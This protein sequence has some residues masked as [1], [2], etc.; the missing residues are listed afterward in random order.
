EPIF[1]ECEH[2]GRQAIALLQAAGDDADHPRVPPLA[3]HEDQTFWRGPRLHLLDRLLEH[4]SLGCPSL[5]VPGFE[6][7]S[8]RHRFSW[9]IDTEQ[10]R[11]KPGLADTPASVHP[12]PKQ[13]PQVVSRRLFVE[14]RH[15][16]K[17]SESSTPATCH[18]LKALGDQRAIKPGQRH[19]VADGAES[20]QIQPVQEVRFAPS[21]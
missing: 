20:N 5:L 7:C 14:T 6:L 19:H 21:L 16:S 18:Y 4:L 3:R 2:Q 13:E 9:V 11:S 10:A 15:V 8:D 1:L 17:R 12:R